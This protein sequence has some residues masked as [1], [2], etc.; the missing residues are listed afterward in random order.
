[1]ENSKNKLYFAEQKTIVGW[2]SLYLYLLAGEEGMLE[3]IS[4]HGRSIS[5]FEAVLVD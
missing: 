5:R 3:L 4:S 2:G 1:M